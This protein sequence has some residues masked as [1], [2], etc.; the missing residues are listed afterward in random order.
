MIEVPR[1]DEFGQPRSRVDIIQDI[2]VKV[3]EPDLAKFVE[4]LAHNRFSL[5]CFYNKLR[6]ELEG[7]ETTKA[8]IRELIAEI[9]VEDR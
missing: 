8:K 7:I 9:G 3:D 1:E 5:A 6:G 2:L 4:D